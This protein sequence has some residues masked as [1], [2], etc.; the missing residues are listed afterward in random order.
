MAERRPYK[1]S[2]GGSIPS[3]ATKRE[4][5]MC[6]VSMVVDHY[7]DKWTKP[8]E[9]TPPGPPWLGA[10]TVYPN[11]TPAEIAEFRELLRKAREYD[12]KHNEPACESD[13]KKARLRKLADELGVKIDFL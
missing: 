8:F 9:Y 4:S 12:K 5:R 3:V 13:E 10:P 1:T 7:H 6:V 11:I 2:V